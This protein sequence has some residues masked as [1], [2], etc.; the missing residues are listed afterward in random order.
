MPQ[1]E[2]KPLPPADA[3][4]F[5]RGSGFAVSINQNALLSS[6]GTRGLAAS[7]LAVVERAVDVPA[8]LRS[9]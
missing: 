9:A 2:L 3:V 8:A 5:F 7:V 1:I 4:C 6:P